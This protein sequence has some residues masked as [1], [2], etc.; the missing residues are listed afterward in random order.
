MAETT[1]IKF[2]SYDGLSQYDGLIKA[3]I[4]NA[5]AEGVATS[6]KSV[7]ITDDF[8]LNFYLETPLDMDN[9]PKE[10]AYS[11]DLPFAE[12]QKLV[13]NA[14]VGNIATFD[15]NGQVVD[16]GIVIADLATKTEVEAVADA[17]DEYKET[18]DAAVDALDKKV[19][20]LPEGTDATTVIE[21][22][23]KKTE[24]IATDAALAELQGAVDA[25]EADYLKGADK[26]ELEGKIALKAD[27]TA[28]EAEVDRATGVEAGLRTDVDKVAADLA[29]EILDA[30]AAEKANADAIV[31]E[32]DR[33]EAAESELDERLEK[34]EAFFEGAAE[35]GEGLQDALDT[36]VEIQTY[37]NTH[38]EAAAKMVE[39]I[40]ANKKAIEDHEATDHDFAG[41][42]AALKE[43]IMVEV[44]KKAAQT[45]FEKA[46]EDLEKADAD[47][48]ERIAKLEAKFDGEDSVAD[49]IEAALEEAKGYT[50]ELA[51]G[52]VAAN[53]AAI[54]A[55][56]NA[57][58]GILKQAKD[59]VDGKDSAMNERVEAL[60]AIDHDHD[61]KDVLDGITAD[62]VA[63]WDAA[64]QNAKDYAKEYVDGL[65]ETMDGRMDAAE[66]A[67]DAIEE[68]LA[69]GGATANAIKAAHDAADAA[70][71][72]VDALEEVVATK[73]A[74]ADLEAEVTR[75]TAKEAELV[76]ADEAMD[77]RIAELEAVEH[78]EISAAEINALFG[79]TE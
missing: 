23:N 77:A 36:L 19:G 45:D 47:Q 46:V 16:S 66:E 15:E 2:L 63:A 43:E 13:A 26:T 51:E 42:D 24:G 78:V 72:E 55:I 61:N 76:A 9:L 74:Q 28:L 31:V 10:P 38:G 59:Y 68:S 35:D 53:T 54:E 56:N 3:H 20:N 39:D 6:F 7:A 69:E 65:N 4:A 50:D 62:D 41:A 25:I 21:Y 29:Q 5:V 48:V 73:A 12:Y 22:I 11:V 57:D 8:K 75:A 34:V 14:T 18:N 70:Q 27:Q 17:L 71:G 64:E 44:A 30:R 67:I 79:I 49:Q 58:T 60:E 32:K 52:A 1:T 37:V 33:A 40:A